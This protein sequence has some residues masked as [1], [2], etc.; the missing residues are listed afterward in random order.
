MKERVRIR[1][2]V[3]IE[4]AIQREAARQGIKLGTLTNRIVKEELGKIRSI[5]ADCCLFP[6][7]VNYERDRG[8]RERRGEAVYTFP[9]F[10][11]RERYTPSNG[12]G[13][14]AGSQVTLC[15]EPEQ[16]ALL[17]QLAEKDRIRGTW[18]T[19]EDGEIVFVSYRFILVGLFL[20]NPLL[21]D[22]LQ[23]RK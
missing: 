17:R 4:A 6:D 13:I 15:L 1:L 18:K 19:S 20:K 2:H 9:A 23:T 11:L 3:D 16:I 12:R 5:G 21:Q 14:N 10:E 7:A 8:E 22:L